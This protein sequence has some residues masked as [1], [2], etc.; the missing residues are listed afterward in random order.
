MNLV[1]FK[2]LILL[3][4]SAVGLAAG[5]GARL[6][7]ADEVADA[8]WLAA[9]VLVLCSLLVAIVQDLRRG[10][11]GVDIVAVLAMAGA[12]LLRLCK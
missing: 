9:I 2:H 4:L 10:K 1:Q 6:V 7:G 12:I 8:A 11:T 5:G 3:I